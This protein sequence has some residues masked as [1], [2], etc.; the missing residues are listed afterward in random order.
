MVR[1]KA[2]PE[3][4]R[5]A[6]VSKVVRSKKLGVPAP[7]VTNNV[8]KHRYR[9]NTVALREIRRAQKHG[10]K[11]LDHAPMCR[12]FSSI[13][14]RV[15]V[16]LGAGYKDRGILRDGNFRFKKEAK[17]AL[18]EACE[19]Y[20]V[21]LFR[22]SEVLSIHRKNQTVRTQDLKVA[23]SVLDGQFRHILQQP[24]GTERLLKGSRTADIETVETAAETVLPAQVTKKTKKQRSED[25]KKCGDEN[26]SG[27]EI[28]SGN[29]NIIDD[30][31][32]FSA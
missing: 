10:I 28:E 29:E 23:S 32:Y 18:I 13:A 5:H 20:A 19:E 21:D 14:G 12:I 7:T 26:E 2:V 15:S 6:L 22:M 31:K 27:D 8:K 30:E 25:E 3:K 1:T 11:G 16:H 24:H 4:R 9:P 17:K